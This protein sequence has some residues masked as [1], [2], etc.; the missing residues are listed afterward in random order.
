MHVFAAGGALPVLAVSV[1]ALGCHVLR[2]LLLLRAARARVLC[3]RVHCA[4][5]GIATN[6]FPACATVR[7]ARVAL[8]RHG[9][10]FNALLSIPWPLV[11]I[12][13]SV[14]GLLWSRRR[15]VAA[16]GVCSTC[17]AAAGRCCTLRG[18]L[19]CG[20]AR[21]ALTLCLASPRQ[22]RGGATAGLVR[23]ECAALVAHSLLGSPSVRLGRCAMAEA[24]LPLNL[25][26]ACAPLALLLLPH[27]APGARAFNSAC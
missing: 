26:F 8:S 23:L 15:A 5:R 12:R 2:P 25:G 14:H 7:L 22:D 13:C 21:A 16:A 24:A 4:V 27:T 1:R 10:V 11:C 19:L 17:G 18:G 20:R 9:H 3:C 6:Y